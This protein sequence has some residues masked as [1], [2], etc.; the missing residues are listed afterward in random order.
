MEKLEM[1]QL[2][3]LAWPPAAVQPA[4]TLA[5]LTVRVHHRKAVETPYINSPGVLPAAIQ[6]ADF[7]NGGAG[8]AYNM[9][10]A[11]PNGSVYRSTGVFIEPASDLRSG[12][13]SFQ[14]GN[15]DVG[16][17]QAGDWL[18]YMVNAN[19]GLYNFDFRVASRGAGG[20]FHLNIDGIN[21]TGKLAIPNTRSWQKYVTL[22][23]TG[24]SIPTT[25]QHLLRV[26]ID[27][28]GRDGLAGNFAWLQAGTTPPPAPPDAPTLLYITNTTATIQ[29]GASSGATGYSIYRDSTLAGTVDGSVTTFTDS[30]LV[31]SANYNYTVVASSNAGDSAPSAVLGVTTY[32]DAPPTQPGTPTLVSVT[33]TTATIQWGASL[34]ASSYAIYRGSALAGTVDGSLTTFTDSGL[35]QL[36]SYNYTVVASNAAGAVSTTSGTL[37]VTTQPAPPSLPGTWNLIFDDEFNSLNTSTWATRD[38]WNSNA[39]T[40]ATFE[41]AQ[42]SVSNGALSVTAI[43][44]PSTDSA[45]VTNPYTSGMINT[46]G[47]QGIQAASFSFTYGYVECRSQ[48][49]P[50]QGMWSA[51]WMLPT[52][53]LD[54]YE[55]DVFENLGRLPTTDQG[56]Y[57]VGTANAGAFDVPAGADLTAGYHTYGVDWEPNSITWYLDGKAV[58]SYTNAGNIVNVPMYL[59]LNLDV[60]GPWAGPLTSAS[61]AQSTWNVDYLRVWQH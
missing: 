55:L 12:A 31:P 57:H 4:A 50:G 26:V 22:S 29:W 10:S 15:Y 47:I 11:P 5:A 28:A 48:I 39:G 35:T 17:L 24:V 8:I 45:G 14:A 42:V 9:V 38:W 46:G 43:N 52:N 30:G 54:Q 56:F 18:Q 59:I 44:Q 7:D 58:Y 13:L 6:A 32:T 1:R 33:N 34:G 60:G 20:T 27:T 2:L 51:L 3:S 16:N 37:S 21:V 36:A 53:H 61:P 41:P 40:Q 49:A 25:G 19:A 23:T